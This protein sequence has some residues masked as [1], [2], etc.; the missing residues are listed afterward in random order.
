VVVT[1]D[2][3]RA[4]QDI[5]RTTLSALSPED[6]LETPYLLV[7]ATNAIAERLLEYRE[8]FGFSH[9]TV[10]PDALGQIEPVMAALADWR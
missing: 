6:V 1:E 10:R 7:G 4:A 2:A 3:V 9:Y 8:R 5:S